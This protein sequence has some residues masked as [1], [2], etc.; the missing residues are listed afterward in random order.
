MSPEKK[1]T[2]GSDDKVVVDRRT[3]GDRRAGQ[4]RRQKAKAVAKER[5]A[6]EDRRDAPE[7]RKVER[8]I[9][10]YN[11]EPEVLEFINAINDFKTRYQKP[12]PT[13]SEVYAI[14][15]DL[16]YRKVKR[17]SD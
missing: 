10:E 13:W 9:N 8:R 16:G 12:F 4:D 1:K 6:G 3:G 7:R 2:N 11:L 17:S 5:R 14:L 15:M